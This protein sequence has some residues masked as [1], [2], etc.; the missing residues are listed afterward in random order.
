[1]DRILGF[2]LWGEYAHYKKI[3]ATTSALTYPIPVKTAVYGTVGAIMGLE[4]AGNQYL[5]H[6]P[7]GQC[8]IGLQILAPITL[9]RIAHN[10]RPV[11]GALSAGGNRKP[12]SMEFVFRPR[13]RIFISHRDE[14]FSTELME[15]LHQHRAHYTP[16]LGLAGLL[17]NF[18]FVG[19]W[20]VNEQVSQEKAVPISTVIPRRTL[21]ALDRESVFSGNRIVAVSQYSLE[22]NTEREVT[23]RDDI[24]L[25]LNGQPI[26]AKVSSY[27]TVTYKE[28]NYN[29]VLF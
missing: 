29:I 18:R 20:T 23:D 6:F 4:K 14:R 28:N 25:D 11:F 19:E 22:M 24:I 3:F 10:L 26:S 7:P 2:D 17:A 9:Q 13:Y 21:I 12:T 5:N 16:T 1:V 27:S 8:R 15:R